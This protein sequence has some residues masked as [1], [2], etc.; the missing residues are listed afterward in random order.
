M[1][2]LTADILLLFKL[3]SRD[4]ARLASTS[5]TM[6][7]LV[8]DMWC[9]QGIAP[10]QRLSHAVLSQRG[11]T[12]WRHLKK[13]RIWSLWFPE[14]FHY[15]WT[16]FPTQL[17]HLEEL[18]LEKTTHPSMPWSEVLASLPSLHTLSITARLCATST[19]NLEG[20]K[21]AL[22]AAA[23][24]VKTLK[25]KCEGL[26]VY[27]R[28]RPSLGLG[29]A[30]DLFFHTIKSLYNVPIPS[31]E[32]LVTYHNIGQQLAP[33]GVNAPLREL[34]IEEG[35]KGPGGLCNIG[36]RCNHTLETLRLEANETRLPH[37]VRRRFTKVTTV[38]LRIHVESRVSLV[39]EWLVQ[40][41]PLTTEHLIIH[42]DV[43]PFLP[44][45]R[46]MWDA[47][48]LH[49]LPKL[50]SVKILLSHA[51]LGAASIIGCL[52]S[53]SHTLQSFTFGTR[54][55]AVPD[56]SD[57]ARFC[58]AWEPEWDEEDIEALKVEET[59]CHMALLGLQRTRP[60]VKTRI[61]LA[62]S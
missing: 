29:L 12:R 22:L 32:T 37:G 16:T 3:N 46:F 44:D 56:L 4:A 35:D 47:H 30:E 24:V 11:G 9:L 1:E 23:P 34:F 41:A 14:D 57:D 45:G 18:V 55:R 21:N 7:A 51:C 15:Q 5:K 62:V 20:L 39:C 59:N 6:N 53:A 43:S 25:I 33:L 60:E 61:N 40:E 42:I 49:A 38:D 36:P 58:T 10:S 17:P 26:V 31:S 50:N 13:L 2:S 48:C 19:N 27:L 28:E 54:Y 8:T 52:D